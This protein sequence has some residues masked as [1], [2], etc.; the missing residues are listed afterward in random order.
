MTAGYV[1]L[2]AFIVLTVTYLTYAL[3]YPERF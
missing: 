1:V 2:I 3:L